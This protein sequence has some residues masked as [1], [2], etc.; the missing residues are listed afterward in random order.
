MRINM[1]YRAVIYLCVD[2]ENKA[3]ELVE[4]YKAIKQFCD[5]HSIDIVAKFTDTSTK[6]LYDRDGFTQLIAHVITSKERIDLALVH[7]YKCLTFDPYSMT[8]AVTFLN[9]Y[10]IVLHH[11]NFNA[12]E[13]RTHAPIWGYPMEWN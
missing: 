12:F 2:D 1:K 10:N 8:E 3:E 7:K 13:L 9:N 11:T 4:Q 6:S 5:L